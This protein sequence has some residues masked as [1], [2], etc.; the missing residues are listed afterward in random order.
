MEI[1]ALIML[2]RVQQIFGTVPIGHKLRK[3]LKKHFSLDF[4]IQ[5]KRF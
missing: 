1:P 2:D 5:N 4:P 3:F